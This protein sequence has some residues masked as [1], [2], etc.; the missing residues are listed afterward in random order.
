MQILLLI[1]EPF[2]TNTASSKAPTAVSIGLLENSRLGPLL[3]SEEKALGPSR[4]SNAIGTEK[5]IPYG[6]MNG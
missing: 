5:E 1:S 6:S 3:T 4:P 2:I